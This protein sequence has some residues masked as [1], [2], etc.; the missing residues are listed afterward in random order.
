MRGVIG[1]L[2]EAGSRGGDRPPRRASRGFLF[3]ADGDR[4]VAQVRRA[5]ESLRAACPDA[6]ITVATTSDDL[7]SCDAFDVMRLSRPED[8]AKSTMKLR[9]IAAAPYLRTVFVDTDTIVLDD[10]TP[11]FALLDRFDIAAALAPI[12]RM[13]GMA[14]F[15]PEPFTGFNTGVVA[16]NFERRRVRDFVRR[17]GE[18][19]HETLATSTLDQLSFNRL[20]WETEVRIC[21]LPPEY[22][23]R[24]QFSQ[25]SSGRGLGVKIVHSHA[26]NELDPARQAALGRLMSTP[27]PFTAV[28]TR[29]DFRIETGDGLD[30]GSFAQI[31]D[32]MVRQPAVRAIRQLDRLDRAFGETA[33]FRRALAET[34]RLLPRPRLLQIG[35]NDGDDAVGR[36]LAGG[37]WDAVLIEPQPEVFAT[38]D[39]RHRDRAE[40]RTIHAAVGAE[41][42]TLPLFRPALGGLDD[43]GRRSASGLATILPD[44][45][46]VGRMDAAGVERIEVPS[47][48]FSSILAAAG[49]DAVD[50]V[51]IDT[52]GAEKVLLDLLL[53]LVSAGD[54]PPPLLIHYEERHLLPFERAALKTALRDAGYAVVEERFPL[55]TTALHLASLQ[56]AQRA[57]RRD[58]GS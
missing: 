50:V 25:V 14:A 29:S 43:A 54:L 16:F 49:W 40:I 38:L 17:W 26:F 30:P 41:D 19:Y 28:R 51:C 10:V 6:R 9:A 20:V 55:D 5:A 2:R 32:A 36:L 27:E 35:A 47:M 21:P 56:Q 1:R 46:H 31:A 7:Q 39:A 44:R 8:A 34:G 11:L 12:L 48:T 15:S 33:L 57:R 37:G 42:G 45:G 23:F 22:N 53:G 52:E 18:A 3:L 13:S 24:A 4:Y 58:A